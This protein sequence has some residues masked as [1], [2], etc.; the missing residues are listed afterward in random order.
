M[1][2]PR[3][4]RPRR[5]HGR[6]CRSACRYRGRRSSSCSRPARAAGSTAASSC[7]WPSARRSAPG[8]AASRRSPRRRARPAGTAKSGCR[9]CPAAGRRR[10]GRARPNRFRAAT[11]AAPRSP[12][13]RATP[14]PGRASASSRS[15]WPS[16]QRP[17]AARRCRPR[18]PRACPRCRAV[19]GSRGHRDRRRE[20]R[21][22]RPSAAKASARLTATVDLPTPPLPEPTTMMLR[23]AGDRRSRRGTGPALRGGLAVAPAAAP[24]RR[25]AR[26]SPCGPPATASAA[27]CAA[28]AR[29]A[30]RRFHA[31]AARRWRSATALLVTMISERPA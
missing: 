14:R 10:A 26:P 30:E 1:P 18:A 6:R 19:W 2:M 12:S 23:D 27:C 20:C 17:G 31:R 11:G 15:R 9:R 3:G 21:S 5:R 28:I 7:R 22:C 25:S 8:P 16:A 4:R 24:C 29:R 13:G